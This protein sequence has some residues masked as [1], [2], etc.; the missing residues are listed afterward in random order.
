[1]SIDIYDEENHNASQ[2]YMTFLL[3]NSTVTLIF[4]CS[5]SVVWVCGELSGLLLA[6][7]FC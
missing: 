7:S 6:E 1:M 2:E 4:L 5:V 3:N